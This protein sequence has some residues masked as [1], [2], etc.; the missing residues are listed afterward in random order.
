[1]ARV[2]ARAGADRARAAAGD[3]RRRRRQPPAARAR[4]ALGV[5]VHVPPPELCTDNAAMIASA[6]RWVEPHAVPGLPRRSTPTPPAAPRPECRARCGRRSPSSPSGCSS[7]RCSPATTARAAASWASAAVSPRRAGGPVPYDG[8]SPALPPEARERVLV[9]LPRPA[10]GE[11]A[12]RGDQAPRQQRSYVR[13]LKAESD[14][15]LARSTPAGS[16][17]RDVV[18]FERTW[19]GF[20]ATI[21][22]K[23]LPGLQSL[24]VRERPNRRFYPGDGRA[25]RPR[26]AGQP[27]PHSADGR[28]DRRGASGAARRA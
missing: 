24:G 17:P 4:A 20:A 28:P 22:A 13:S 27:R 11:L 3:R 23:E 15:L 26:D 8:R 1:M 19:H 10:L 2:R 9:E 25:A 14:A 18:T 12:R 7:S 5:A 16:R 6:A 21:T